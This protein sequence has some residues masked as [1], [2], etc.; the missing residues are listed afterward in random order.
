MSIICHYAE[1]IIVSLIGS[2]FY[3]FVLQDVSG[4]NDLLRTWQF[5]TSEGSSKYYLGVNRNY[6]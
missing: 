4:Q 2:I 6:N 3:L 5:L 1:N